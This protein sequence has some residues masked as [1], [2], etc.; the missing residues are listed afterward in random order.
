MSIIKRIK[1]FWLFEGL[2]LLFEPD[3]VL[4]KPKRR[5]GDC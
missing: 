4:D 3:F 1:S 5:K 2:K